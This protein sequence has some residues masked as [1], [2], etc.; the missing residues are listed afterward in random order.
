MDSQESESTV[1]VTQFVDNLI[2]SRQI[3]GKEY[4]QLAAAILADGE[5]DEEERYQINRLFD[6]IQSGQVKI[7]N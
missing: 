3:S 5:I 7:I 1:N 6:A 4:N 2:L